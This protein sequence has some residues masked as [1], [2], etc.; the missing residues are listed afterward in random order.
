[1]KF[2]SS[3]ENHHIQITK[4]NI[5][6]VLEKNPKWTHHRFDLEIFRSENK[7]YGSRRN[8]VRSADEK[9]DLK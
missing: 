4:I 5:K 6:I 7:S 3:V 2:W 8:F 9:S 1:M